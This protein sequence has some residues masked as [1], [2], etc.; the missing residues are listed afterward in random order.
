MA[1]LITLIVAVSIVFLFIGQYSRKESV[2]GY[3]T[4]T[5]GTARIFAPQQG[6]IKAVHVT[7]G[8]DV[9]EGEPLLTVETAQFAADGM[10]VNAT[11]LATLVAQ[12]D[13]LIKQI[14]SEQYR[15]DSEHDRLT[16]LVQ[17]LETEIIH[18]QDQIKLQA[19]RV[20]I[21]QG[22]V[23]SASSLQSKGYLA[24]IEFKRRQLA[25]LEQQQNLTSLNQ[26]LAARQNQLTETRYSLRQLPIARAEKIQA[27]RSQ[28]AETERRI[29]EVQGRRA[30]VVRAPTSG[31]VSTL[32]AKVGQTIDPQRPQLEIIP[33]HAVLQ[34][35]LF[36]P[37][38]A[39]GFV[40]SG[41]KVRILY[42][43]FPY[44]RFGVYAGQI[45]NISQTILTG[46]DVSGPIALKEPA[47]RVT[48]RLDRPDIDAY[49]R[50]IPLQAGMLLRADI[51]LEG[52]SLM[53]W[54]INPLLSVRM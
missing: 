47:Y 27:L 42:D 23:S 6:Y 34:A 2:A 31:R 52:R 15:T 30:Y 16:A 48:V 33:R 38:R 4:P 13:Q 43:A 20:E 36:V 39:I 32:Q 28:L 53:A 17:G 8:L 26:Q 3:L 5:A 12:Q 18:L 10:D 24:D 14:E 22:F 19:Q 37:T 11:M 40:Q 29:A 1:W 41:Q 21:E 54:L 44:Q 50:K 45:S 7:E 46:S 51:I 9:E 49:R 35:E 25:V